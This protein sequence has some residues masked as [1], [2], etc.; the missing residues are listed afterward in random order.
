MEIT[1][2]YVDGCPNWQ[3][4]T[5]RVRQALD[6]LGHADVTITR[7][8]VVSGEQAE[9]LAFRGSPTILLDGRDLFGEAQAPSGLSCRIYATEQGLAGAPSVEQLVEALGG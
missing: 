8:Q 9:A 5:G 1:V 2:L 6:R 4:A 3:A 7:Q